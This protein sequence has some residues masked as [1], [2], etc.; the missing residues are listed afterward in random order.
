MLGFMQDW[1]YKAVLY[2]TTI[3]FIVRLA[4]LHHPSVVM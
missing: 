1:D 3:A 4:F 2:L